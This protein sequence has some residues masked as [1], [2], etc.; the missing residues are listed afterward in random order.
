MDAAHIH[1]GQAGQSRSRTEIR[2]FLSSYTADEVAE[3]QASAL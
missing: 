1:P 3:E 2:W